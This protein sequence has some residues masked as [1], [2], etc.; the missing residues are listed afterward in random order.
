MAIWNVR[1]LNGV[2]AKQDL[3]RLD[4]KET[5]T[6]EGWTLHS[7]CLIDNNL[8]GFFTGTRHRLINGNE[9]CL[10]PIMQME[11][12]CV[13]E[14]YRSRHSRKHDPTSRLI[15]ECKYV[16]IIGIVTV[17]IVLSEYR[18]DIPYKR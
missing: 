5:L 13:G 7:M 11:Q 12:F 8:I 14:G 9:K 18:A 2:G 17:R 15:K 3:K 1:T 4:G 16:N 10:F 6:D